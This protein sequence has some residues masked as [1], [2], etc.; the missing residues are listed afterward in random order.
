MALPLEK[1]G[2]YDTFVNTLDKVLAID[3]NNS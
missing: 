1:I 2:R 3:I